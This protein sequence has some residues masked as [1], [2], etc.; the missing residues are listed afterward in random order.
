MRQLHP[1]SFRERFVASG[2]YVWSHDG[3]ATGDLEHWTL[4]E[5]GAGAL[6]LRADYDGRA[7]SGV[8][9]LFEGF[10]SHASRR[11]ERFDLSVFGEQHTEVKV[12]FSGAEVNISL[13]VDGRPQPPRQRTL[14]PP[15]VSLPPALVAAYLFAGE[16]VAA[17]PVFTVDI[18]VKAGLVRTERATL[19]SIEHLGVEPVDV[20]GRPIDARRLRLLGQDGRDEQVWFDAFDVA[21]RWQNAAGRAAQLT[22]YVH[23]P[24]TIS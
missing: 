11:V 22:R 16:S 19:L 15:A 10:Y 7:G 23:R 9:W 4:H 6:S 20:D 3:V 12:L 24:E 8:N 5:P 13:R 17:A 18:D 1:V 2:T 21:V 14:M